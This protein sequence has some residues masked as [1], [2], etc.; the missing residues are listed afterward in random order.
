M[1]PGR[2][3]LLPELAAVAAAIHAA[4]GLSEAWDMNA[5][6]QL[7]SLLGAAGEIMSVDDEPVGLIL[8]RVVA[9][10]AEIL[11]IAVAPAYRRHGL[12]RLMLEDAI[13]AM[14]AH[15]VASASL[16]VAVD[17][18]AALN[19]YASLGFQRRGRRP[20]YYRAGAARTDALI[21]VRDFDDEAGS[22]CAGA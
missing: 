22:A 8:W 3:P 6:T 15:R 7:S 18:V 20:G 12:G 1:N 10:E 11:T 4:S 14:R 16:E 21:L 13:T 5:F 17:N 2:T 9:D 19:L